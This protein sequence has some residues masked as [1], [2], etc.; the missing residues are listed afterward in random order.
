MSISIT[1]RDAAKSAPAFGDRRCYQLPPGA[2]GLALRAVVRTL[3]C[4]GR[5]VLRSELWDN[6]LVCL[7]ERDVAEGAD[8]LMVKPGM[9]YLDIVRDVKEKVCSMEGFISLLH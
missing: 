5:K 6:L 7:Q 8:F 2:R 3:W 1:H 9:P 4:N